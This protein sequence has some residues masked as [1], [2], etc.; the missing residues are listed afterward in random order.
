[1][2]NPRRIS[3]K[4]SK[5]ARQSGRHS[6][7]SGGSDAKPAA[8]R[9]GVPG[10]VLRDLPFPNARTVLARGQK[11]LALVALAALTIALL[12][13]AP[14]TLMAINLAC[15]L[16]YLV[17]SQY[18]LF[19]Q[20]V[21]LERSQRGQMPED[22]AEWP[23]YTVM[24]P[25][26]KEQASSLYLVKHLEKMDYPRGRMQVL[27]LAEEDDP[28]TLEA[29]A[30]IELQPQ[31]EVI[32]VPASFPR[33]KPK[34]CNYGLRF[35][36]GKYLVI[37]DAE[38]RPEFDQL[39]KAARA[40]AQG[41]PR[42]VCLQAGLNYYN[43]DRNWLTRLFTIDY[44]SWFDFSLHGL[45]QLDAPVP[46]GGTSNHFPVEALRELKGWDP[47]NVTEDCD[48]GIRIYMHGYRVGLLD[49]TTWEEATDRVIPWILQ[50]SR[51]IKGYIQTYLVHLRQQR[52]LVRTMGLAK[53][54]HFHFLFGA[55]CF[56]LLVNPVYW[57]LTVFWLATRH[58]WVSDFFPLGVL[59]IAL[60]SFLAGN[61]AFILAAMLACLPRK[62]YRLIP[63]CL[64][65]PLYWLMLSIGAWK[66]AL[67][68]ITAPF[69]WE[70]TPH[71]SGE[72][73]D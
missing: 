37:Y 43:S 63:W 3:G 21:S 69:Y 6:A 65:T 49:S 47:F 38:D 19:I 24:V 58:A 28:Q 56:V 57:A 14:G 7:L 40:F 1:M 71:G 67:Q 50:R 72:E 16:L 30:S 26:Y 51:W 52:R 25:L 54:L 35:A 4:K 41:D 68:L 45:S 48:L 62:N 12:R 10:W 70:K 15:L 34:A 17:F 60:V 61:A 18:K 42:V 39:K 13:D 2:D 32:R 73:L 9:L 29:L 8:V 22:M 31:F 36:T 5:A 46:L 59:I 64:L 66:G 55:T 23:S 33:T 27:L 44:S 53:T 11:L 20:F